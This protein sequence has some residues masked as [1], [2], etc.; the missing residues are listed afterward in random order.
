[1]FRAQVASATLPFCSDHATSLVRDELVDSIGTFC[2]EYDLEIAVL[3]MAVDYLDACLDALIPTTSGRHVAL[4]CV[5]IADKVLID[6]HYNYSLYCDTMGVDK[7]TLRHLETLVLDALEWRT[8]RH[9]TW[10]LLFNE[11]MASSG[12]KV[13]DYACRIATAGLL[14]RYSR[15]VHDLRT[16][17]ADRGADARVGAHS[18]QLERLSQSTRKRL[19]TRRTSMVCDILGPR[20]A[21]SIQ[22]NRGGRRSAHDAK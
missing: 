6:Q 10:E 1:M 5:R 18:S 2:V 13:V 14:M 16:R 22:G 15:Q 19:A 12:S 4:T 17:V 8:W 11:W 9:S 7:D 21:Q 3:F 20:S